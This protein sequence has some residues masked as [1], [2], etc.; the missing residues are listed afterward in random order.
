MA[1]VKRVKMSC[2]RQDGIR[3]N[4]GKATYILNLDTRWG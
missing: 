1:K 2:S 4:G 3:R